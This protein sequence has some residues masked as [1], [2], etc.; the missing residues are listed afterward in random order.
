VIRY[1]LILALAATTLGMTATAIDQA[2]TVRGERAI[3][4][5]I[6][7]VETAATSLYED[8]AVPPV[9]EGSRR[10][11]TVEIHD[12]QPTRAKP[13]RITFERID[14]TS[15]TRVTYQVRGGQRH[16]R[17][18]EVPIHHTDGGA[19]ELTNW[20]GKKRLVLRLDRGKS[21]E[22]DVTVEP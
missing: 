4:T 14:G 10:L 22:K 9:G 17:K 12:Q 20:R 2:G 13:E 11:I 7:A 18:L 15:A 8:G 5:E 19:L 21:G 6:D 3:Q 1:V 16:E